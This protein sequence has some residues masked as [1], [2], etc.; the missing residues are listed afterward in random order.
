MPRC[1]VVYARPERQFVINVELPAGAT[2]RDALLASH[3]LETCTEI[4]PSTA[5]LGVFGKRVAADHV[6]REGDRVEIYRPLKADPRI[7]RRARAK[8]QNRRR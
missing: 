7:A 2:A 3:L 4:D 5:V 1:E 8:T 6:L